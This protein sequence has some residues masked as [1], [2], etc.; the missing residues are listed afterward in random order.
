LR[1]DQHNPRRLNKENAQITI[2]ALGYLAEDRTVAGGDLFGHESQP[3]SEVAAFGEAISRSYR[4]HHRTRYNRADPRHAHQPFA[5]GIMVRQRLDLSRQPFDPLVQPA[6]VTGQ[7]LNRMHHA[8]REN[9]AGRGENAW[10]FGA[11]EAQS[12]TD[13]NSALQ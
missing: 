11:Q 3:R 13:G 9:I 12:L 10:Q 8:W 5:T 6:P 4:R 1:P 7:V 2:A